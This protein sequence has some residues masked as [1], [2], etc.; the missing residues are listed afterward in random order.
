MAGK[1]AAEQARAEVARRC[2]LSQA[3]VR[4]AKELGF[5]PQSL[6]RNIPSPRQPW[7]AP[8]AEWVRELCAKRQH[9]AEQRRRRRERAGKRVETAR[10]A[11]PPGQ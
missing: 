7:K 3:D 2:H 5:K 6:L 4:M 8:V 9:R 1:A 10:V 11:A